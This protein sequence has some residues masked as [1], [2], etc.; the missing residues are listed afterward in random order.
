MTDS[1]ESPLIKSNSTESSAF[2]ETTKSNEST[3][4]LKPNVIGVLSIK[5]IKESMGIEIESML[6]GRMSYSIVVSVYAISEY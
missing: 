5:T 1:E 6:G 3:F 4:S 2:D